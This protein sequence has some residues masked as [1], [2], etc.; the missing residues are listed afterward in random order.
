MENFL[1]IA[2][3]I[4]AA[5]G[6]GYFV[7]TRITRKRSGDTANPRPHDKPPQRNLNPIFKGD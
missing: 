2:I 3:F 7:Y 5:L 6:M 1:A 4:L